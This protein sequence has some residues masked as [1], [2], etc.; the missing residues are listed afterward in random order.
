MN[1]NVLSKPEEKT[2]SLSMREAWLHKL[3]SKPYHMRP[4]VECDM[5]GNPSSVV[6]PHVSLKHFDV[7]FVT[8]FYNTAHVLR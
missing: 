5:A 7:L 3:V 1:L 2:K 6:K 8:W 4:K